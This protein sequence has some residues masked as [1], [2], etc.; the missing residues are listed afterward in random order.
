MSS[1]L[2][3]AGDTRADEEET[4]C[5]EFL[6]AADGIGI[7]GITTIDDDV[8]RL[9]IFDE[10]LDEGVDGSAGLDKENDFAGLFEFGAELFDGPSTDNLSSCDTRDFK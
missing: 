1:T 5:F 8:T 7:V 4:L 10:L 3:A 6:T 2:F 9:H